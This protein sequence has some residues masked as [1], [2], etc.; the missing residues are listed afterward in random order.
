MSPQPKE[1]LTSSGGGGGGVSCKAGSM[2]ALSGGGD[3]VYLEMKQK[4][5]QQP[6]QQ[7]ALFKMRRKQ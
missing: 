2:A 1:S 7:H 5:A 6:H 3:M 4:P